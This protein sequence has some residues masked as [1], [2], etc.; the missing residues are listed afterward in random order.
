MTTITLELK[1]NIAEDLR[2]LAAAQ[3]RSETEVVCDALAAYVRARPVIK[4]I[5]KYR[6][7]QGNVSE[8]ARDVL[9][10]AAKDG[11]WP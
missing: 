4:G 6:S 10:Q 3:E 2:R 7:G 5:G 9:R 1:D 11:L 8:Q